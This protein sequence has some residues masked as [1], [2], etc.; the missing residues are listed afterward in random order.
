MAKT[1]KTIPDVPMLPDGCGYM[2]RDFGANYID[3]QC[4]GGR[5]YD[6]DDGDDGCLNEPM[7]YLAC[8]NCQMEEWLERQSEMV[9]Q[10]LGYRETSSLPEWKAVCRFA[11]KTN[12][13][14][15]ISLL[16]GRFKSVAYLELNKKGDDAIDRTWEFDEDDLK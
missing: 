4:F 3:S 9:G 7:E 16:N 8:P 5:L 12:R 6:L 1:K 10:G 11:L 15:A 13:D 2:G 14:K